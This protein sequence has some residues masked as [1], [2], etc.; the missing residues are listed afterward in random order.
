MNKRRY[1][2]TLEELAQMFVDND[3]IASQDWDRKY[4]ERVSALAES[5]DMPP[6]STVS[7]VLREAMAVVLHIGKPLEIRP[8]E[9]TTE[10]DEAE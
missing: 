1:T 5:F 8:D 2:Y 10:E 7:D 6:G 4:A 3:R 9:T